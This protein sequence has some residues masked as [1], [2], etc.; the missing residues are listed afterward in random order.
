M[1]DQQSKQ[2]VPARELR[3]GDVLTQGGEVTA[4]P[5]NHPN[6]WTVVEVD[7]A[8]EIRWPSEARLEVWR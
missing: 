6:G 5:T 7:H 8:L 3:V 1:A 4:G 2:N